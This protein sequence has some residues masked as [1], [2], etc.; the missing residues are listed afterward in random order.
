MSL[1][2]AFLYEVGVFQGFMDPTQL[3]LLRVSVLAG[4]VL[5]ILSLYGIIMGVW[6]LVIRGGGLRL[7]AGIGI[8]LL[9]GLFGV[10]SALAAIFII[11]LAGGT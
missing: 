2:S 10:L 6:R 7:L 5:G 11:T 1:F 9:A 4:L 8:Y 3:M